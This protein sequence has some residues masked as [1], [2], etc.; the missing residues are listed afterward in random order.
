M[1]NRIVMKNNIISICLSFFLMLST[2]S[3]KTILVKSPG[4][5]KDIQPALQA[6]VNKA[7]NGDLIILPA[8]QFIVNK[9]VIVIY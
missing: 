9:E 7:M 2:V 4:N 1:I 8:G 5:H 6:A 3:A